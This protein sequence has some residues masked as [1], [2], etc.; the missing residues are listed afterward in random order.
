MEYRHLPRRISGTEETVVT[1]GDEGEDHVNTLARVS[2]ALNTNLENI[3]TELDLTQ[4]R[5]MEAHE[6]IRQLEAHLAGRA[7]P[8][9]QEVEPNFLALSP[10]RKKLRLGEPGSVTSLED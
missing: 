4:D 2:A 9:A 7:P 8:P 10:P 1:L 3:T 5:L 6:R